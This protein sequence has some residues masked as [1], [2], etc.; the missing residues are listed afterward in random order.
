MSIFT[1]RYSQALGQDEN[2]NKA[3]QAALGGHQGH[4]AK[5]AEMGMNSN[6]ILPSARLLKLKSSSRMPRSKR[7]MPSSIAGNTS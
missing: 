1:L 4:I 3:R 6:G 2:A 5:E 7:H